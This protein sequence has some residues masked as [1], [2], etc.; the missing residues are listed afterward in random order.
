MVNLATTFVIG[1]LHLGHKKM[2]DLG[3]RPYKT[4]EEHDSTLIN[5]WNSVIQQHHKVFVLGDVAFG[6]S[7]LEMLKFAK[8][9]KYLVAGNHDTLAS[10]EYLKYFNKI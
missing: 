8:G 2:V 4:L 9:S 3:Q 6:K 1:D 10:A 7:A 5:N